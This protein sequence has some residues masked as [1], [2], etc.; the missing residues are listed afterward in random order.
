MERE[1][2]F[3][4]V[5]MPKHLEIETERL[6]LP[7]AKAISR[8]LCQAAKDITN[9]SVLTEVRD[10]MH[11]LNDLLLNPATPTPGQALPSPDVPTSNKTEADEAP[12]LK[13]LPDVEVYDLE[14]MRQ[15]YGL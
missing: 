11:F 13:P 3:S 15:G 8:R 5:P 10:R 2:S 4:P 6:T 1:T 12:P 14:Q 7:E 9:A